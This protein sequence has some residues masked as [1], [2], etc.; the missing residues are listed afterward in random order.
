MRAISKAFG[1]L[2]A[3]ESV[4]LSLRAGEV[5]A[6]LGENGAGKST[7][8]MILAGL[9]EPDGG[10]IEVDGAAVRFGS[11]RDAMALGIQMVHQ[12]FMLVPDLTVAENVV[13]GPLGGSGWRLGT[14]S[15]HAVVRA[16]GERYGLPVDPGAYI[17]DLPVELRQRVEIVKALH[18]W[19][20]V[21]ILD[22]PT[23]VLTPQ[24]AHSF[25]AVVRALADGGL[26]VVLITHHIDEVLEF[27]DRVTVLR[28]GRRVAA[29]TA[30]AMTAGELGALMVD[31]KLPEIPPRGA[32]DHGSPALELH[33]LSL[34]AP[35]AQRLID[36]DLEV[37]RGEI[38]GVVGVAGNGQAELEQ[39][40]CGMLRPTSGELRVAGAAVTARTP[41][42]V[43]ARGVGYVPGDRT[44]YG[45]L[46]DLTVEENL[47]VTVCRAPGYG[48]WGL[49]RRGKLRREAQHLLHEF[50]IAAR[51]PTQRAS[52]LSGGNQQKLLLARALRS[53]PDVVVAVNP[54]RG[55]DVGAANDIHRLLTA[56]AAR[57]GAVLLMSNDLIEILT[58]SH[59]VAVLFDGRFVGEVDS[60]VSAEELGRMMSG[61]RSA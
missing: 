43:F 18:R 48:R 24:E 22:E 53:K 11:P 13:L 31:R 47:G 45:I 21:L 35:P 1:R 46:H 10:V 32:P 23:A 51:G 33:S 27:A 3:N 6:V 42:D 29:R 55:L 17:A 56:E 26:A 19:S 49:L 28:D 50:S 9:L 60:A 39:V 14:R 59:R 58:L 34:D 41:A 30:E 25:L 5:H 37:R 36:L 40:L 12:H 16:I 61:S 52:E 7:L 54:T 4:D 2:L 20:R 15:S 8:M 57:G 44:R 38:V